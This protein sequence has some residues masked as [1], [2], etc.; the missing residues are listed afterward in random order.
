MRAR[1]SLDSDDSRT[2]S[3]LACFSAL[4]Q[5]ATFRT[6]EQA[7]AL[8]RSTV[9]SFLPAQIGCC[10][11]RCRRRR[12][13]CR[14]RRRRYCRRRCQSKVHV[15][16]R[17]QVQRAMSAEKRSLFYVEQ[18]R[19]A[20]SDRSGGGESAVACLLSSLAKFTSFKWRARLLSTILRQ[21]S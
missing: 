7:L 10:R 1:A 14:R 2:T 17:A 20:I 12:R 19:R 4:P 18:R 3:A 13:R 9:P 11:R 15:V 16:A 5:S 8:A 21:G 6:I